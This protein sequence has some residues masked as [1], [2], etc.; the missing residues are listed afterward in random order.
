M[1]LYD[2]VRVTIY[3]DER[4]VNETIVSKKPRSSNLELFRIVCMLLIVAHH[5]VVC[6]RL[7]SEGG[8]LSSGS[9]SQNTLFLRLFG[10]WGKVGINCF[11]MITGY[12]MCK[13]QITIRKW[14]KLFLE[15]YF[16]S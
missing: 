11:L 15:I 7:T 1:Q 16:L 2:N 3:P 13:S 5:Y 14:L 12:F 10:M 9:F 6:S 8:P 4:G